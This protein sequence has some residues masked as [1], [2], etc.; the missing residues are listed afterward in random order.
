MSLQLLRTAQKDQG[1][2]L[3]Q[4]RLRKL[5]IQKKHIL[6]GYACFLNQFGAEFIYFL[7]YRKMR[8]KKII[9]SLPI[10]SADLLRFC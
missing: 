10:I 3:K 5:K 8:G 6:N 1:H 4:I 7:L 2:T 9:M